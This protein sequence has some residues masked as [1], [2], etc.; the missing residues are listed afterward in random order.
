MKRRALLA[1][2]SASLVAV[3]GCNDADT[4]TDPGSTDEPGDGTPTDQPPGDTPTPGGETPTDTPDDDNDGLGI[5]AASIVDLETVNRTY[6]LTSLRYRTDDHASVRL[7]FSATAT[8][9][10]PATVEATLTN[11]NDFENTFRLDWTPPFGELASDPPH[12]MGE[13]GTEHTFRSSLVFAPTENHDLVEEGADIERDEDGHWRLTGEP[14]PELPETVR[15]EPG[16]S[17]EGEYALVGRVEGEGRP[18]GV[19]E[20]SRAGESPVSVTVW[21]TDAPGPESESRFAGDS[22]PALP[23]DSETAWYHDADAGTPTFVRPSVERT[24]LPASVEFTFVNRSRDSTSCGHWT[25][26]KLQDGEWFS[27][28][29]YVQTADCRVV[30][31]GGAKTW[32]AR[33]ATGEMA[34]CDAR[35]FEFLGG[36]RYAAVAGYGH[37]TPRSGALVEFDA[38][39]VSVVP[40]DDVTS[41]RSDGTVTATADRWR[42]APDDE[43]RSRRHLVLEPTAEAEQRYIP[44]QVMR[45][46]FRG[47]RNTLAFVGP[48]VERVVLR[49]D[50]RIVDNVTGYDQGSRSFEFE[51]QAYT[52]TKSSQ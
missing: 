9:E 41:E 2:L 51:G 25:F 19:Y 40:T 27:L 44:E 4:T 30:S 16:E 24:D 21:E 52:V 33:A 50:D 3:A 49:T 20:F 32:T 10:Q 7:K 38:P 15:L 39:E 36:G 5:G 48:D 29:P 28:G 34:P 47:L 46:R 43:H 6:A 1:S 37:A 18:P 26:Y 22:V 45:Q 23:G 8:T 31:P 35:Q 11:E 17:V 12:P 14:L 42:N 13:R